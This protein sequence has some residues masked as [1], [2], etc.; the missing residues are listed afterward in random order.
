M[1][2][3]PLVLFAAL[4]VMIYVYVRCRAHAPKGALSV[5]GYVGFALGVGVLAYAAGAAI[6]IYAACSSPNPGNLCGL[7]GVFGSG[8]LL[9]GIAL[10]VYAG[11]WAKDAG[12]IHQLRRGDAGVR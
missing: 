4:V 9:S 7:Y 6:G 2:S 10:L 5:A 1:A 3:G 11:F 12:R 8:P